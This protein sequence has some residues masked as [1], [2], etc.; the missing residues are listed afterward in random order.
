MNVNCPNSGKLACNGEDCGFLGKC[1]RGI[2]QGVEIPT[3]D[4]MAE[5]E[6]R[7]PCEKCAKN[8]EYNCACIWAKVFSLRLLTDNFK[9]KEAL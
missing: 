3:A 2:I 8:E 7:R 6:K 5:L 4:L 9:P 1:H